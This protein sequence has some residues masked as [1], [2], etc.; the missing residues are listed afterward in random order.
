MHRDTDF[1]EVGFLFV[2]RQQFEV[3]G[4]VLSPA[5]CYATI[6]NGEMFLTRDRIREGFRN[7]ERLFEGFLM[8]LTPR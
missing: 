7:V 6:G 2:Y 3:D 8:N 4:R 1:R 5:S